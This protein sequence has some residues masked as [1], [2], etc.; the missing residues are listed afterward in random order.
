[1]KVA[2]CVSVEA[3]RW[4]APR[5]KPR[6]RS[7]GNVEGCGEESMAALLVRAP[8]AALASSP[9]SVVSAPSPAAVVVIPFVV[10]AAVAVVAVAVAAVAVAV[11]L[12]AAPALPP[13]KTRLR[14]R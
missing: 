14:S 9:G 8:A 10:V 5:V 1:M 13:S 4:Y 3:S 7:F 2:V 11:E 12:E 6:E